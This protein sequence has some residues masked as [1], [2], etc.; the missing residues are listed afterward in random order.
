MELLQMRKLKSLSFVTGV[1]MVAFTCQ[2]FAAV[3][4][5]IDA[6]DGQA[7][8][9]FAPTFADRANSAGGFYRTMDQDWGWQHNTFAAGFTTASLNISAWDVDNPGAVPGFTD[10]ID[11]I[12]AL[13]SG[14]VWQ[15]LGNLDGAN[16]IFSFTTFA[17]DATWFDEIV[18]GLSVRMLIDQNDELW[19]V[20]LAKSVLEV[21]GG[22][23][24]NPNPNVVPVPAA[25]WLFGT[26]LLGLVG[27]NK[28]RKAA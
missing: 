11:T 8:T 2:S 13:D 1:L 14:G 9:F 26:A 6:N 22:T 3:V 27:F 25:V 17:L 7:G 19:F 21:D 4:D 12:Q 20:S 16:D 18:A 15:T 5:V 28:R 23:L 24:P 10:E